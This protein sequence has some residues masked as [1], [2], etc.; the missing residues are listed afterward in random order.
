MKVRVSTDHTD[1]LVFLVLQDYPFL[2]APQDLENALVLRVSHLEETVGYLWFTTID[3]TDGVLDLHICIHSKYRSRWL[4]RSL[5][6]E[7][8]VFLKILDYRTIVARPLPPH[9]PLLRRIGFS[10]VGPLLY[11]QIEHGCTLQN[12]KDPCDQNT[13]RTRTGTD[14]SG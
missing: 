2:W 3:G 10:E 1:L 11:L 4:T 5:V 12:A 7:I 9:I 8:L 14:R 6:A 13:R